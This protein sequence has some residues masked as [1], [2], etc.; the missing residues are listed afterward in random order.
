MDGAPHPGRSEIGRLLVG[1]GDQLNPPGESAT[2]EETGELEEAGG[3]AGVVVRSGVGSEVSEGIVVGTDDQERTSRG[4]EGRDDVAVGPAPCLKRLIADPG[5]GS[6]EAL[7]EVGRRLVEVLRMVA[8]P[9]GCLDG[10]ELDVP[11]QTIWIS[12]ETTG[13]GKRSE[14]RLR[15]Y[16][17]CEAEEQRQRGQRGDEDS[18][19][20]T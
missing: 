18:S 12:L 9:R 10:Q 7:P 6:R 15:D 19:S 14:G 5:A 17:R 20:T 8:V 3:T 2:V 16:R 13:R 11:P 1:V 4:T